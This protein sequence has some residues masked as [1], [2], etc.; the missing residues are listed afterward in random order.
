V[1]QI[2]SF[3]PSVWVLEFLLFDGG[4][5][6]LLQSELGGSTGSP[7][8]VG[9]RLPS[10][11]R[12]VDCHSVK[13][14]GFQLLDRRDGTVLQGGAVCTAVLLCNLEKYAFW[15]CLQSSRLELS[16]PHWGIWFP[17]S[18]REAGALPCMAQW[19]VL[20]PCAHR[21]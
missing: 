16:S 3:L 1:V 2:T 8:T 19:G 21:E 9:G 20:G 12:I 6:T 11:C 7:C 17:L 18:L 14:L 10:T 4:L 13:E 5:G 15:C